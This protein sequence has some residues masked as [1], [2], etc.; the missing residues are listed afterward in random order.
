M[1]VG[2]LKLC[3]FRN[4]APSIANSY[5]MKRVYLDNAASTPLHPEVA[6]EVA[7]CMRIH[8]GNPSSIHH[9]GRQARALIEA[10]R[11]TIAN[12]LNAGLGEIFFTSGGTESN[13]M[14]IKCAVRDFGINRIITTKIEHHCV[15][16]TVECLEKSG[17][18]VKYV[19]VDEFGRIDLKA[20][21]NELTDSGEP[22]LVT[23]M[24]ANNEV[25]TINPL[26]E[27]AELCQK[28]KALF[29]SDTVQ[30]YAHYRLNVQD[31]PISFLSGAA[32]KFHG[33]KGIGF[34]YINSNNII[35][36]FIDGGAQERNMRAGTENLPGIVGIAKAVEIAYRDLDIHRECILGL[37]QYLKGQLEEHFDGISF[38]G[39]QGEDC[40]YTILNV[41]FPKTPMTELM[42]MSLDVYGI[43]SSGG[44]A[45]SSGAEQG[46]HVLRAMRV[47]ADTSSVRFSFSHF[48]THDEI[49]FLIQQ[50][51]SMLP[52]KA[53]GKLVYG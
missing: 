5:N 32:H 30:T 33:P 9:E 15:L 3:H 18:T 35:K 23:I 1:A 16:H 46:S 34:I 29:H 37:K 49:D 52:A 40:L 11:K 47:P 28:H 36:P 6:D 27:I 53:T 14:A 51:K 25:G 19:P 22:T 17:T 20:L 7:D 4:L 44:S 31:T 13:N 2:G 26:K 48:N 41:R 45:C 12:S 50:L 38:N 43:A 10:A 24:H 8:Y 42:V 39:D 21:E